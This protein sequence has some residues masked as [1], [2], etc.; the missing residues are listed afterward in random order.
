MGLLAPLYALAA[1]AVVGPVVF[2]LIRRQPQGQKQFSSLMFLQ[3]SPPRLTRRSR[4][5]HWLLLL[6]RIAAIT[7]IA[8]AFARPYFREKSLLDLN[9][10]G[11]NLVILLDTSASMQRTD[12]WQ[13]AQQELVDLVDG[14]SP[15]DRLALY[16]IDE[17][18]RPVVPLEESWRVEPDT[19]QQAVLSASKTLQPTW[20]PTS[21]AV[22]LSSLA[23]QLNAA[24]VSGRMAAGT[25]SEIVLITD[26][27][28][29]CGV[30]A[31]QGF[32]WPDQITLDVRPIR[33]I[34]PGNARPTWTA[35]RP[36]E[37]DERV[38]IRIENNQQSEQ[39][40]F[41]LLWANR[42]GILAKGGTR[43]QVP[44]GQVR[45][46]PMLAGEPDADRIILKGDAWEADNEVAILSPQQTRQNIIYCGRQEVEAEDDPGYFL[47]KTPLSSPSVERE[48]VFSELSELR[49]SM[50]IPDTAAIVIETQPG[51][52]SHATRLREF[53]SDGGTVIVLLPRP[54][55]EDESLIKQTG[56]FL[57]EL[58][59][60]SQ[61][62]V[63]EADVN[64]FALIGKVDYRNPVLKPFADT[65]F[66]DF[67][68]IRIWSYRRLGLTEDK[69][70]TDSSAI[71]EISVVARLDSGDP[72][73]IQQT[74]DRGAIWLLT[75]G[76]QPTSR[77]LALSSK[78]VP[79]VLGILDPQG[80]TRAAD[81]SY[82][83]GESI[84]IESPV[85]D[86]LDSAGNSVIDSLAEIQQDSLRILSPGRYALVQAEGRR[87]LAIRIPASESRLDVLDADIFEQYGVGLGVTESTK[88]RIESARQLQVAELESQQKLWQWL[89]AA[90]ILVLAVETLL[91]GWFAKRA[92]RTMATA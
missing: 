85:V 63:E 17:Q 90:C 54:M 24:S 34:T 68:K 50:A 15:D 87:Q 30:E 36:E 81:H 10:S 51:I 20:L 28:Q 75:S 23:D 14:L 88:E 61:V 42:Q 6:L 4:L 73:L 48:I 5:D 37:D 38:R 64:N 33:P 53:A 46:V 47:S 49:Q 74:V 27:H 52:G 69:Q 44:P 77:S 12:V 70:P 65:R 9:I 55:G 1:L 22:G 78:F 58:L 79:I 40:T 16:T 45:V 82:D 56:D 83:V 59:L 66:N 84:A 25:D 13:Q 18:L 31:L 62:Q 26:L 29:E 60:H 72:W 2:H 76:W 92:S 43:I 11:R 80:K 39:Q 86:V 19:S 67:S 35:A 3:P 41:E 57:Q 89:L 71:S 8:F 91:G 7:L 21:L 32:P